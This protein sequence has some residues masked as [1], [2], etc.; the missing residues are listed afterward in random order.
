MV[1]RFFGLIKG[2]FFFCVVKV[3]FFIGVFVLGVIGNFLLGCKE[4]WEY[5]L[6]CYNCIKILLLELC[7]VFV[8]SCYFLICFW[9]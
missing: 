4:G 2:I 5:C 6:L 3:F 1:K 9:L 8:I 7:M